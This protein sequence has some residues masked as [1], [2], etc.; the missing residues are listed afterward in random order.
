[1]V[2]LD[3]ILQS[4]PTVP[5]SASQP[6]SQPPSAWCS[7][8]LGGWGHN[9]HL[10]ACNPTLV[11]LGQVR[12]GC[13]PTHLGKESTR[14]RVAGWLAGWLAGRGTVGTDWRGHLL[15][16]PA[17]SL[18]TERLTGSGRSSDPLSPTTTTTMM[19]ADPGGGVGLAGSQTQPPTTVET[20]HTSGRQ[21]VLGQR[22]KWNERDRIGH[23][24][25]PVANS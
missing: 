20:Q 24:S 13:A 7:P 10:T 9:L 25:L 22:G 8:C 18:P 23:N 17:V 1:M 19:S 21:F 3:H 12:L 11:R 5:P 15:S 6:A 2:S 4:V 16:K 14:L